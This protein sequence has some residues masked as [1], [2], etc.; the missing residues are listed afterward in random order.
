[1][2]SRALSWCDFLERVCHYWKTN[3][4]ICGTSLQLYQCDHIT[5]SWSKMIRQREQ[6]PPPPRQRWLANSNTACKA[7]IT[8]NELKFIEYPLCDFSGH[9][10]REERW[11]S[12]SGVGVMSLAPNFTY[13]EWRSHCPGWP[14]I[15]WCWHLPS[16]LC[17]RWMQHPPSH[18]R[19][20]RPG[21][22]YLMSYE[23]ALHQ[24]TPVTFSHVN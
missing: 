16:A 18:C 24:T 3:L 21:G 10:T 4:Q 20:G 7:C 1:M 12:N 22:S 2:S 19:P 11:L 23:A 14:G 13:P 9:Y 17:L 5:Q 6:P 8:H 15:C